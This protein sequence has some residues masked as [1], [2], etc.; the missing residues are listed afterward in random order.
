[1]QKFEKLRVLDICDQWE[2]FD[3]G[4]LPDSLNYTLLQNSFT[5]G[6]TSA[7]PHLS[8]NTMTTLTESLESTSAE[9]EYT[10]EEL[11]TLDTTTHNREQSAIWSD[12]TS[13]S[14][15]QTTWSESTDVDIWSTVNKMSSTFDPSPEVTPSVLI[16]PIV[17]G[18]SLGLLFLI[19]IIALILFIK[20]KFK[21]QNENVNYYGFYNDVYDNIIETSV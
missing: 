19:I 16:L 17:V 18:F 3:C 15:K 20:F 11:T 2:E 10:T 21:N 7:F 9:T 1:M 4:Y 5:R 13:Y 12:Q 6:I 8:T 14:T